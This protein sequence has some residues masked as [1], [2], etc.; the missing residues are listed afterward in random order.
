MDN[1]YVY[2][3]VRADTNEI[4]Y[5]GKGKGK[6]AYQKANRNK[7]WK[8]IT[9]KVD[10]SVNILVDKLHEDDALKIERFYQV[11]YNKENIPLCNKCECGKKGAYGYK[12]TQE[13]IM[14]ISEASKNLWK[15]KDYRK[16]MLFINKGNSNGFADKKK[17]KLWHKDYGIQ[18]LTKSEIREKYKVSESHIYAVIKG[19]RMNS[20]G[21]KLYENIDKQSLKDIRSNGFKNRDNDLHFFYHEEFGE[22]ICR[23]I[24]LQKEFN[25]RQESLLRVI[26]GKFH[27]V[28]GWRIKRN[29]SFYE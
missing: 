11:N 10:Y 26:Q 21:W 27:S 16:M 24:D 29:V 20:N 19:D 14:K 5:V 15:N 3:H 9:S 13:E 4:F 22:R 28:K 18:E 6:R 8:K 1:F 7:E 23:K 17:Y 2:N 12:H 25:L